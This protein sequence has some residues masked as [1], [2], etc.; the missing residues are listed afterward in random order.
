MLALLLLALILSDPHTHTFDTWLDS[1]LNAV[2]FSTGGAI[3]ASRRPD[4]PVGWLLCLSGVAVSTS[5]FTSPYA[6]YA[7]LA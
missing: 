5:S 7:L 4:N 1:T 3:V 6:I 2:F